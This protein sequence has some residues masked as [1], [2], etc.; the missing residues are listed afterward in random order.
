MSRNPSA[1]RPDGTRERLTHRRLAE[2]RRSS[3][4]RRRSIRGS[5][6]RRSPRRRAATSTAARTR[7]PSSAAACS[8]SCSRSCS[9]SRASA[10]RRSCARASCRGCGPRATAPSTCASTI[11]RS[12]RRR[13][14]QIKQAIFRAT[15]ASGQWTQS[16][17]ADQRRVAVGVPAP[18]RRRPARRVRQDAHPAADLRPVRGN[19]SRS[20]RATTSGASAPR[21]SSRISPT[22]SRTARPKA[23]EAAMDAAT[24]RPPRTLRLHARR[25]PDPDRA[26]RGLS[27]APRGLE[28]HRCPRSRRT[29]CGSR[30]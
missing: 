7:S 18:P 28:G 12:R 21:S 10:R 25:L 14:E 8:A 24:K 23:L 5:A 2:R 15:Q 6:S 13:P 22:W 26:A 3:V 17:V 20:R 4:G 1:P 19:R 30:A 27:R 11:R 9:A 29:G 16:G